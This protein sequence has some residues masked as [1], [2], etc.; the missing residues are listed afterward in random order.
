MYTTYILWSDRIQKYYV[1]SM[2]DM[3]KRLERHNSSREKYTSIG[4]PWKIVYTEE[5]QTRSEA[6]KRESQIKK[7]GAK[8]YIE[9]M[10]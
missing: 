10:G 8:R 2:A 1:G 7:R 3:I 9:S 5:F 6:I 4:V